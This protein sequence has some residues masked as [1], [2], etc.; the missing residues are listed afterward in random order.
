MNDRALS[1]TDMRDDPK[2]ATF[3]AADLTEAQKFSR[4]FLNGISAFKT[5]CKGSLWDVDFA[6]CIPIDSPGKLMM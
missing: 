5:D 4:F 2:P 6:R 1:R 3:Q